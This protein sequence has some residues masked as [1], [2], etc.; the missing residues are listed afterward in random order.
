[1]S[2]PHVASFAELDTATLYALLRLRVDVFV[3]EQQCAYAELDGRDLEPSARH[4]WLDGPVA[5]LRV[6]DDPSGAARIGRVCVAADA[7]GAGHAGRLLAAAL[8]LIGDREA[9]LHAQTYATGLYL[10]AGFVREGSEFVEDGIPHIAMRR[11]RP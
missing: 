2:A 8:D 11:P 4:V 3:A 5:Y 6:L 7:R 10:R 1:M 9:V